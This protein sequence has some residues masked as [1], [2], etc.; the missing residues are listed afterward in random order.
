MSADDVPSPSLAEAPIHR[1]ECAL[2]LVRPDGY[3]I[4]GCGCETNLSCSDDLVSML[5][6]HVGHAP[7]DVVV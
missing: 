6:E 5:P 3:V 2:K 7:G 4:V 1:D